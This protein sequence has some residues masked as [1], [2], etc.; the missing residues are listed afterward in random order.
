MHYNGDDDSAL[1]FVG[2]MYGTVIGLA[3]KQQYVRFYCCVCGGY[4]H[5][6]HCGVV[7]SSSSYVVQK[8]Y[9]GDGDSAL[10][11]VCRTG[12]VLALDKQAV[13][14]CCCLLVRLNV[15]VLMVFNG[16]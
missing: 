6:M 4:W 15:S 5:S 11:C 1:I 16:L 10:I 8:H 2:L 14:L 13:R 9:N 7:S 12:G 3:L